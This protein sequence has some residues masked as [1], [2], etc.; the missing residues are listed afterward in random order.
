[1]AASSS[2]ST[3]GEQ[4]YSLRWNDFQSSILSSVRQ[5]RDVED[6][7]D[8]TLACDSCSFTAHKIVL[9]ACS[10]YLRNL[11]KANPCPHP[12]VILKDVA[13]SDMESLLRF[14]YH[15]EVHVGQEQLP[16]F[17]KTAQMLQVRGLADVNSGATKIPS[18]A[19]NNG[20]AP[21]TPRNWQDNGRGD[22][23]ESDMSPPEKRPRSYSPP[24]GNHVEQKTDLQESLLG[25]ALEGGPTI[26]TTSSNN[27][28]AQSTGEDS[29]S[30]SENEED[31]SNHGSI[32]NA[33][34][35]E[36]SDN[37]LND[38][39]E[40]HRNSFPA[41]L[42]SLQGMN[43][44]GPSGMHQV[45]NQDPNYGR[46]QPSGGDGS[47]SS[48]GWLPGT[49]STRNEHAGSGT[50]QSSGGHNSKG[51][52][53]SA[54]LQHHH[55]HQ[56][57][58]QHATSQQSSQQHTL[59][60]LNSLNNLNSEQLTMMHQKLQN[61]LQSLQQSKSDQL[62]L[63]L[64]SCAKDKI[65][66]MAILHQQTQRRYH[67]QMENANHSGK[68]KCPECGKIYSNNSNLKQHIVNVHTIQTEYISCHVCSKQF[69][70]K[71]YLQIH[72]LSMHGIR[73]RKSYPLYQMQAHVQAQQSLQPASQVSTS[74]QSQQQYSTT[75][76]WSED[77]Q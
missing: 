54:L 73:K 50:Y 22:L 24:M 65:E 51:Q 39:I 21:A 46:W 56:H 19:G 10:P 47:S 35:T 18:S 57:H 2:S 33:V 5:L 13:S 72:L 30:M 48:S 17:L 70:T 37:M 38:S 49:S 11:L 53:L 31:M 42:L 41:A 12:I 43:M 32:L 34:K 76:R 60:A 71:Q 26:H 29:N 6:F 55:H 45:A 27:V 9:S 1:M 14:M 63:M 36:P 77:K 62:N 66:S 16:A 20:S 8:V 40:H 7:V 68:P 28:Q 67:Q 61:N 69:K 52:D 4:Q 25:Q 75:D 15:G 23:N 59:N 44:P 58:H 3:G 74:Q 64:Q